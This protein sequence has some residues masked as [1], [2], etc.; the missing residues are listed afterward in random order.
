[1][2]IIFKGSKLDYTLEEENN[3]L[4][5]IESLEKWLSDNAEVIDEIKIDGN[6]VLPTEKEELENRLISNTELLEIKTNHNAELAINS[7]IELNEYLKRFLSS[8]NSKDNNYFTY[9]KKEELIEG[10]KWINEVIIS[11]CKILRIDINTIFINELPLSD[12]VSKNNTILL[13]LDTYKYDP[14]IFYEIINIKLNKNILLFIEYIPKILSKSV[15]QLTDPM[16]LDIKNIDENLVEVIKTIDAF[17][18]IIPKIGANLQ[19]GKDIEA[20]TEIKNVMGMMENLIYYLRRIEEILQIDY[21]TLKLDDIDVNKNNKELNILLQQLTEA[22][23]HTDIVSL[24]DI[25]EYELIPKLEIYQKIFK[26]LIV[27]AKKKSYY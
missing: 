8:L 4:Q 19:S 12:I 11:I 26:E 13:E 18:P 14:K 5:V 15:F 6:I 17:L 22:F 1:M 20:Y 27:L 23:L 7:L 16:E 9:E 24:G 2:E 21:S 10:L 3:V 25:L